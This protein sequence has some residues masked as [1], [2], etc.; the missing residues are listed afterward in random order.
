MK[1]LYS[2]IEFIDKK[3][4]PLYN[5]N[6]LLDYEKHI[7][8]S[9]SDS[10]D[11]N[12]KNIDLKKINELIP[13]FREVF[14]AKNFNLHK[15]DYQIKNNKQAVLMLKTCLEITSIPHDVFLKNK[16]KYL[17][18]ISKNN[19]LDDYINT[20]KMSEIRTLNETSDSTKKTID[21]LKNSENI[22][23]LQAVPE[24]SKKSIS[25]TIITKE[26]LNENIKK[27]H[28]FEFYL[29]PKLLIN[30]TLDLNDILLINVK[31]YLYD[32]SINCVKLK[33]VSKKL[34]GEPKIS[35][36]YMEA[37]TNELLFKLLIGSNVIYFNKISDKNLLISD[38]II[39]LSALGYHNVVFELHNIKN[40]KNILDEFEIKLYGT[41]VNFYVDIESK[42]NN[43]WIEQ[44]F[45]TE[46]ELYNVLKICHG[47]GACTFKPSLPKES[48]DALMQNK[49]DK[50]K[51]ETKE[52]TKD[53]INTYTTK[54]E[55]LEK[56]TKCR[57][58]EINFNDFEGFFITS[59]NDTDDYMPLT[60]GYDFSCIKKTI[61]LL[62][63]N[64]LIYF[65]TFNKYK[66]TFTHTY[67]ISMYEFAGGGDSYNDL[68]FII[69]IIDN[70]FNLTVYVQCGSLKNDLNYIL[71]DKFIHINFEPTQHINLVG[72]TSGK[73]I[74]LEFETRNENEP[75]Q[76]KILLLMKI[77]YWQSQYRKQNANK[78]ICE[79]KKN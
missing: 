75:I 79:Y 43:N 76:H 41:T 9:D 45:I 19:I 38:I 40:V 28:E 7:N 23:R 33:L 1:S 39:P 26:M 74:Y 15:T 60:V 53:D 67:K 3:L 68:D 36:S 21:E 70:N 55:R 25:D 69:D 73:E 65:R 8:L 34:N 11:K 56:T 66:N 54:K 27:T 20:K 64:S 16:K 50:V 52:K 77:F 14:H 42:I 5:I 30:K 10:E 2:Q 78:L 24:S 6:G 72:L 12:D 51:E 62:S 29:S 18:L 47:M 32:K 48:F 22:Y 57:G 49:N 46:N 37:L 58:Y 31:D 59:T 71:T 61:D 13:E 63:V 17:R 4:L 44:Q 35:E